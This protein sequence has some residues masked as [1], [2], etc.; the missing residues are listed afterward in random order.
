MSGFAM[1]ATLVLFAPLAPFER[2]ALH[3]LAHPSPAPSPTPPPQTD[4]EAYNRGYS[5]GLADGR[6]RGAEE[7]HRRGREMGERNGQDEGRRDGERR[8]RADGYQDGHANGEPI[9][10]AEGRRRGERDGDQKGTLDGRAHRHNAGKQDGYNR[11]YAEGYAQGTA[12]DGYQK[13]YAKGG[14]EAQVAESERGFRE[15]RKKG[16]QEREAAIRKAVLDG[17]GVAREP[18]PNLAVLVH[19]RG[20]PDAHAH[21]E[22]VL[23]D[24]A[25]D[26]ERGRKAGY[27]AGYKEAY[28]PAYRRA[29]DHAYR[30]NFDHYYRHYYQRAYDQAYQEGHDDGYQ[31]G[32]N[33]AYEAAYRSAYDHAYNQDYPADYQAGWNEGH[34][35]GKSA[36]YKQGYDDQYAAGYKKGWQDTSAVVYP[37][38]FAQGHAKGTAEAQAFYDGNAVLEL[39]SARLTDENADGGY[40]AGEKVQ[41]TALAVNFGG[42]GSGAATLLAKADDPLAQLELPAQ[43]LGAVAGR[44]ARKVEAVLATLDASI[45]MNVPIQ[46]ALTLKEGDKVVGQRDLEILVTNPGSRRYKVLTWTLSELDRAA[47]IFSGAGQPVPAKL[48]TGQEWIVRATKV[49]R[50]DTNPQVIEHARKAAGSLDQLLGELMVS[51]DPLAI[52]AQAPVG[53]ADD[54]IKNILRAGGAQ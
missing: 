42:R 3:A 47:R 32:Y 23:T 20:N 22:H 31:Y 12:A 36:G 7:G 39:H 21:R 19:D 4:Q 1:L 46:F 2:S 52:A 41:L 15:G 34:P 53:L 44:G 27:N 43:A 29:Y 14:A 37:Q 33:R 11:G 48:S 6:A 8:G 5:A 40:V 49:L 26:Y 54:I 51:A 30:E 50:L 9:G 45:G 10:A 13:G 24:S 25:A 18:A 35:A 28:D 17:L 38:H 16:Y